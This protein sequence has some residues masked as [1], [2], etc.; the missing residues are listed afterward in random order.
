[1]WIVHFAD[2]AGKKKGALCCSGT[3]SAGTGDLV[4]ITDGSSTRFTKQT[5]NTPV[6]AFIVGLIDSLKMRRRLHAGKNNENYQF[7]IT[8]V[9]NSELVVYFPAIRRTGLGV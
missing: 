6:D 3:V 9:G 8:Q 4:L 1:L 5:T 7:R 2:T